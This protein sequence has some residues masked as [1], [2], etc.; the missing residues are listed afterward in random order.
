MP[1]GDGFKGRKKYGRCA[2]VGN[3]M[4]LFESE[5]GAHIDKYDAVGPSRYFPLMHMP[6]DT[7]RYHTSRCQQTLP[8]QQISSNIC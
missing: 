3:S 4:N 6:T 2:V 5:N 7:S 1:V 8:K